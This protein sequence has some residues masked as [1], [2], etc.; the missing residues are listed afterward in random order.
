MYSRA[1]RA[2]S[3]LLCSAWLAM[4]MANSHAAQLSQAQ[5]G[6]VEADSQRFQAMVRRDIP[7]LKRALADE[8]VYVHSSSAKQSKREHIGDIE[9]GRAVYQRIDVQEQIPSIY[10]NT[11]VIQGIATFTTGGRGD[12]TFTLRYTAV[13][14]KR[15]GHWQLVAWHCTRMPPA[16][17]EL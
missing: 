16:K 5:A 10:G 12:S 17:P 3:T 4:W 15:D 1:N 2:L 14:L 11:G 6:L 9:S 7:A 8:L 13:Y